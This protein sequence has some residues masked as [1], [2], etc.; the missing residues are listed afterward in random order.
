MENVM[1]QFI[2]VLRNNPNHAYDFIANNGYMFEKTELIDIIKELLYGIYFEAE[3]GSSITTADHDEI[4]ANTAEG[5]ADMYE[6][7]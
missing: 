6:E 3:W 4:L 2:E 7:E 1:N 5:L